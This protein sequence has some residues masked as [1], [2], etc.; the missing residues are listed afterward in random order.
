MEDFIK[1]FNNHQRYVKTTMS[2]T[3]RNGLVQN[4]K[5]PTWYV[6]V[7]SIL[8]DNNYP[9]CAPQTHHTLLLSY[10]YHHKA[11]MEKHNKTKCWKQHNESISNTIGMETCIFH[12]M[13][14]FT[15]KI[16]Q[17]LSYKLHYTVYYYQCIMYILTVDISP[18]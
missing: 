5:K 4:P 6:Q 14:S 15:H 2:K 8:R 9:K 16:T 13:Q 3:I 10:M 18:L 1:M 12:T 11:S 7:V 17:H